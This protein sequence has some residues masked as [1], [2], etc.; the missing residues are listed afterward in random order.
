MRAYKLFLSN[1]R[2]GSKLRNAKGREK[3]ELSG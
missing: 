2:A 1:T 3:E